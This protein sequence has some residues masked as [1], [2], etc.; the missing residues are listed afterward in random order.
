MANP[1]FDTIDYG[2]PG[3]AIGRA[4]SVNYTFGYNGPVPVMPDDLA[5]CEK[6]VM[7][8]LAAVQVSLSSVVAALTKIAAQPAPPDP[9]AA[10]AAIQKALTVPAGTTGLG[11]IAVSAFDGGMFLPLFLQT[12]ATAT[13]PTLTYPDKATVTPVTA[14]WSVGTP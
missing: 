7:T 1:T 6:R 8:A 3:K 11:P 10:L 14:I 9:T 13:P 12:A 4:G 2:V 5:A